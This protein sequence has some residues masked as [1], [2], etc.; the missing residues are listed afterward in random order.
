MPLARG[1]DLR[2]RE[3]LE[4]VLANGGEQVVPRFTPGKGHRDDGLVDERAEQ[5][6][7]G[8]LVQLMLGACGDERRK[9]RATV[10]H[11]EL[12]EQCLLVGVQE[13]VAPRQQGPQRARGVRRPL[14]AEEEREPPLQDGEELGEAEHVGARSRELDR[15]RKPVQAPGDLGDQA[16]AAVEPECRTDVAGALGEQPHRVEGGELG[17]P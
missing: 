4:R 15:Q 6:D 13:V 5:I 12:M 14:F 17:E 11:G 8:R 3:T 1:G 16:V 7:H 9:R 10:V 2:A